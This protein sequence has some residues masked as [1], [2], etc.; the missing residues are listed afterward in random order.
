[1]KLLW[2]MSP[3][4]GIYKSALAPFKRGLQQIYM[5]VDMIV[6]GSS[7]RLVGIYPMSVLL[8]M[9]TNFGQ[10]AIVDQ[11]GRLVSD[12]DLTRRCLRMYQLIVTLDS[13][14]AFLQKNLAGDPQAFAPMIRCVEEL[15]K[16]LGAHLG[17]QEREAAQVHLD[18]YQEYLQ[19]AM[20]L[21]NQMN[22]LGREIMQRLEP[23][24]AGQPLKETEIGVLDG[25]MLAFMEESRKRVLV[26]L[27]SHTART[28]SR[29]LLKEAMDKEW[30]SS[31]E[32]KLARN[33]VGLLDD[34]F[35][36]ERISIHE[37]GT[38]TREQAIWTIVN[39]ERDF[40]GKHTDEL[41]KKKWLLGA[42]GASILA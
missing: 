23:I 34:S 17:Q 39:E 11:E 26:L 21:G 27:E 5:S 32:E 18:G 2:I 24:R 10:F 29:R 15:G 33:V 25:R 35:R 30:F 3:A 36:V 14:L 6:D 42:E 9:E 19:T 13:N 16:R 1:M 22:A 7:Y 41:L 12:Y 38:Q 4:T 20:E 37:R 40:I 31:G 28:E 8:R